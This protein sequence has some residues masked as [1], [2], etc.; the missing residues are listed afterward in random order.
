MTCYPCLFRK[1]RKIL[2]QQIGIGLAKF[3]QVGKH[4]GRGVAWYPEPRVSF[5]RAATSPTS[6]VKV[7]SPDPSSPSFV[8]ASA[9]HPLSAFIDR[10]RLCSGAL[11]PSVLPSCVVAPFI[12]RPRLCH[13]LLR[14]RLCSGALHP[15]V[16]AS[17]LRWVLDGG[18]GVL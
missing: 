1:R 18:G 12:D 15:S 6:N 7:L 8:I 10:P 17:A 11:H 3:L 2:L 14:H 16:L 5:P 4:R 13:R 9:R